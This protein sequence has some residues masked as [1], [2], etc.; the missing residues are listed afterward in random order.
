MFRVLCD[1]EFVDLIYKRESGYKS[2]KLFDFNAQI[3]LERCS[4]Q[5]G[6]CVR[7]SV[8]VI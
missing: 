7:S 2:K 4:N 5:G 8:K 6:L 1:I 3:G